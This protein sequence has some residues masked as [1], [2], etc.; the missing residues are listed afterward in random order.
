MILIEPSRFRNMPWKNGLGTT[1]EIHRADGLDGEMDWRVSIAGVDNN[2]PFS[3]F[4]GYQRH[5]M[6][7]EG[8]GMM[9]EGGPEGLINA[10]P[11]FMPVSFSGDWDISARLLGG[12]V[13][14]FNL[15][16]RRGFGRGEL[17][18]ALLPGPCGFARDDSVR[19]IYV[20]SGAVTHET[21]AIAQ[22]SA[23]ML[24][25]QEEATLKPAGGPAFVAL[26]RVWPDAIQ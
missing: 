25:A 4:P 7:I 14:D 12:P 23:L 11:T 8:A 20:L 19:L 16:V 5:L 3:A 10:S 18:R 21:I 22:G 13:R 24:A 26:C 2:G 9:L 15:I 1:T 17:V 6:V